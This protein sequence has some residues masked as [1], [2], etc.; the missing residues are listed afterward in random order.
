MMFLRPVPF[1]LTFLSDQP[2]FQ[3][4]CWSDSQLEPDKMSRFSTISEL[5]CKDVF[6]MVSINGDHS[7]VSEN[8]KLFFNLSK[9]TFVCKR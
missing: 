2:K 1:D 8:E 5:G 6:K 3:F 9:F 7:T 4:H